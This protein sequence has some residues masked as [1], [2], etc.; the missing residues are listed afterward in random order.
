MKRITLYILL[1]T[2]IA[3]CKKQDTLWN[4]DWSVPLINDTLSLEHLTNDTTLVDAGGFYALDL[5]R[6]LFDIK[7]N[8]FIPALDTTI[9][10]RFVFG[11]TIQL[12][13]GSNFVNS[14]EEHVFDLDDV[15]LKEVVIRSGYIDVRV[16]NVLGTEI[17]I[18]VDLP[19]ATLSGVPFSQSYSAG[20]GS[21]S[22]PGISETTIDL[23][24][25]KFDLT[26]IS[27][28]DFNKLKTVIKAKTS[29]TGTAV[30]ITPDDTTKVFAKFYDVEI[31]YARG[32]FGNTV[33]SDT[34]DVDL[35]IM[36]KIASGAI[37]L[38][39]TSITFDIVNGIKV[40]AE[41]AITTASN[42]NNSGNTVFLTGGAM[43]NTFNINPATGSWGTLTPSV[44]SLS[45]TSSNSN[46]EQYLENLGRTHSLGYSMELNPWGNVSG[47]YDEVFPQ[48]RVSINMHAVMPFTIGL[49]ALVLRDTFDI[50]LNQDPEKTRVVSGELILNARNGF[51]ISGNI[52]LILRNESGVEMYTINGSQDIQSSLYGTYDA[53]HGFDVSS[54]EVHFIIPD[55]IIEVIN[56]VKSIV[57]ETEFNTVNPSNGNNEQMSIPFGAFLG[58][59]LKSKFTTENVY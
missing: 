46:I 12:Q 29:S 53:N 33:V 39:N 14:T 19:G 55:G 35:D 22:N 27:G 56:D 50:T 40:G 5:Y 21:A 42:I 18:D 58:I 8:D 26:G 13:P 2:L 48:S 7:V 52:N 28:G 45:F 10:Q 17:V 51:P 23:S 1:I 11:G 57:V 3:A 38:P 6:T 41:G 44:K 49:D 16:E 54:S 31:D 25:Y 30:W 36:S 24:G 34:T 4:G 15:Q 59:K 47:G 20:S 9:D 32:Y 37:D 43:G